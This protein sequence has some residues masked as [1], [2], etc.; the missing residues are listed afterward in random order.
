[1]LICCQAIQVIL[2]IVYFTLHKMSTAKFKMFS[3]LG[4]SNKSS[5]FSILIFYHYY[6]E[7]I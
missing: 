2:I 7:N 5:F 1:M 6:N 3:L 4:Y